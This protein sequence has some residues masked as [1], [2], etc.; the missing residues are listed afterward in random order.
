MKKILI[1]SLLILSVLSFSGCFGNNRKAEGEEYAKLFNK[2]QAELTPAQARKEHKLYKELSESSQGTK[3]LQK[4]VDEF[5]YKISHPTAKQKAD[6]KA[7]TGQD[8]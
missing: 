7:M 8:E 3:I 1:T 4:V 6:Y 2:N 5:Y